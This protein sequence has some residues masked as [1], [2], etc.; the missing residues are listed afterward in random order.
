AGLPER[1]R[2]ALRR[3]ALVVKVCGDRTPERRAH[4][5]CG[6]RPAIPGKKPRLNVVSVLHCAPHAR[7]HA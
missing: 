3:T 5:A 4:T 7:I 2:A 1:P 6:M